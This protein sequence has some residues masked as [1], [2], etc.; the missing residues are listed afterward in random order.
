MKYVVPLILIAAG[1]VGAYVAF[2]PTNEHPERAI[3][4]LP[5]QIDRLTERTTR[6]FGLTLGETQLNQVE[7]ILGDD[8][9]MAILIG[10]DE[11]PR[12]EMYYGHFRA[13]PIRGRLI[14]GFDSDAEQLQSLMKTDAK[15]DFTAKGSRKYVINQQARDL[16]AQ[17]VLRQMIF[18]PI[19]QLDQDTIQNRFGT[20]QRIEQPE[21]QVTRLFYPN[22]GVEAVLHEEARDLLRYTQPAELK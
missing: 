2:M 20:P 18:V 8:Y 5:W 12:L 13:G 10:A 9:E 22:L 7:P 3:Q 17:Q 4:G 21:P 19:V 14:L 15:P 11:L 6:V 1:I 16:L